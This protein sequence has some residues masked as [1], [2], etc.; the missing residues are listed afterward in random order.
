MRKNTNGKAYDAIVVGARCGGATTAMLLARRGYRVLMLDSATFPS[1]TISTHWIQQS[2]VARL[3]KWGLL[4]EV[5]ATGCPSIERVTFDLGEFAISGCAPPA[6]GIAEAIAPRRYLLDQIL[7]EAAVR[8]GAEMREGVRV[9]ELIWEEGR[10]DE[11]Q[12]TDHRCR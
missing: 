9:E 3:A 5:L 12:R 7:L 1:D 4:E 11:H 6:G 8:E 2:G 10:G